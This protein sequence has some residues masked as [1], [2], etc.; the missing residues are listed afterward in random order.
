[1]DEIVTI[2]IDAIDA[3]LF[4]NFDIYKYL[5]DE[6]VVLK[7]HSY[8]VMDENG[9]PV[10]VQVRYSAYKDKDGNPLQSNLIS[11]REL[12]S[13]YYNLIKSSWNILDIMRRI[14]HYEKNLDLLNYTLQQRIL[15]P[16]K[17]KIVDR[18][19][20]LGDLSY[21]TLTD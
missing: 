15:F 5:S 6:N 1:M 17:S 7:D 18:L 8:K 4:G 14:P 20:G 13:R 3:D 21:L 9:Q 16:N 11:Y 2:L 12:S 19:I 10:D